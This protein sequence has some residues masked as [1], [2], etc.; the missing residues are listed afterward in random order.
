M[1]QPPA[2]SP[3]PAVH[4]SIAQALKRTPG[5]IL[6]PFYRFKTMDERGSDYTIAGAGTRRGTFH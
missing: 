5:E 1:R 6:G 3:C 2:D 4:R